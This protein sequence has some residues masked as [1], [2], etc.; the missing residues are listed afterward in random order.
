[1]CR[2]LITGTTESDYGIFVRKRDP[3]QQKKKLSRALRQAW[4]INWDEIADR[5]IDDIQGAAPEYKADLYSC[6]SIQESLCTN[7]LVE[8]LVSQ[9]WYE[10]D[11]PLTAAQKA[12]G[13]I[14]GE[15]IRQV[16]LDSLDLNITARQ[17]DLLMMGKWEIPVVRRRR[18]RFKSSASV[19]SNVR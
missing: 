14:A 6:S 1:M 18:M 11:G 13:N 5:L 8:H 19:A 15:S 7:L 16:I 10:I 9:V 12:L 3:Q 4:K 17:Y 2:N